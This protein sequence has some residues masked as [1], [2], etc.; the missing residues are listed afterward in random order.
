MSSALTHEQQSSLIQRLEDEQQEL[1]SVLLRQMN[2]L[3]REELNRLSERLQQQPDDSD[4]GAL[5]DGAGWIC[6]EGILKRLQLVE[7]SLVLVEQEMYGICSDCEQPIAASDLIQDPA[8]QRC[9]TCQA[10]YERLDHSRQFTV[11]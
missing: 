1:R 6:N 8:R 3:D 10:S 11:L 7:A 9:R 4:W 5:L 2:E